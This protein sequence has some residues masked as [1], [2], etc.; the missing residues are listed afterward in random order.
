MTDCFGEVDFVYGIE[1][2]LVLWR[3]R[4]SLLV[5]SPGTVLERNDGLFWVYSM[6]P[7]LNLIFSVSSRMNT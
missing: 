3:A 2:S 4:W 1:L 6:S 5:H 7:L